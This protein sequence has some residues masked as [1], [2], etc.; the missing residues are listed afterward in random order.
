MSQANSPDDFYR[1]G[2]VAEKLAVSPRTVRRWIDDRVLA[3]RKLGR[4]V[5]VS[6]RD[7]QAFLEMR[8]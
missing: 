4:S 8:R 7:L 5:R 3:R 1:I 2:E 6:A